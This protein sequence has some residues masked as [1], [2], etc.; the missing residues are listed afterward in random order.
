M[1]QVGDRVVAI[2]DWHTSNGTVDEANYRIRHAA[3]P[4]TLTVEFDVIG[5][6][7]SLLA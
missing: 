4:L 1:L 5:A 7:P 6:C 2:N 3:S